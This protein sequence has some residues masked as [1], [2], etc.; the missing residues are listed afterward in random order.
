VHAVSRH[1]AGG[2]EGDPLFLADLMVP[3]EEAVL[4]EIAGA[5]AQLEE[6]RHRHAELAGHKRLLGYASGDDYKSVAIDALNRFLSTAT[7]VSGE[8]KYVEDFVLVAEDGS[9]A[10]LA[11]AKGVNR[12]IQVRDVDQVNNHRTERGASADELPGLLVVNTFRGDDG[13]ER[14]TEPVHE[15][16][17]RHA[18]R[19]RVLVL[20][21]ADL[22]ELVNVS[23]DDS[24]IG[25]RLVAALKD[26][27]WLAADAS[28]V[29]HVTS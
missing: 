22:F 25:D 7:A 18:V 6:L 2:D 15:R 4:S 8:E 13:L 21:S 20:R 28:G 9:E 11:E 14:R 5:N 10:A 27:G 24:Q 17:V 16:V 23:L 3:G 26:G 29:R 12:G 1:V 19:L